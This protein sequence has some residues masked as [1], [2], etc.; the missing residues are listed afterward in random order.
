MLLKEGFVRDPVLLLCKNRDRGLWCSS[1]LT[2]VLR[3]SSSSHGGDSVTLMCTMPKMIILVRV[4]DII[5]IIIA[6]VAAIGLCDPVALT[7]L[8]YDSLQVLM[9]VW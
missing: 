5:I 4:V 8:G 9:L 7:G 2:V 6:I 1:F 3:C